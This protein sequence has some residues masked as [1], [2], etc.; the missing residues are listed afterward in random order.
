MKAQ[1]R[2]GLTL[3]QLLVVLALLLLLLA[4][5]LPA[6]AQARLAAVRMQSVNNLKQIALAAHNYAATFNN[7]FP[8][9][10]DANNFSAAARL[11][12]YVEQDNVFRRIDFKKSIDDKANAAMRKVQI[13]TF[14]NPLDAIRS[15]SMDYGATNYLFN[16]GSQPD[17]TDNN[18]IFYRDSKVGI[19]KIPDGTSN[20]LL[21]VETLKGDSGVRAVDVRRQHVLLKKGALGGLTEESGVPEWKDDK[22]IAADRGASWMDGRFLQGT[23]TGTRALNDPRPDVSCAG[24]GGLSGLRSFQDQAHIAMCDGSVRAINKNVKLEVWKNLASANDGQVIPN[25]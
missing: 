22:H 19:G 25:F 9:G 23:F 4:L 8:P 20:T 21:V 11:L 3:F 1:P 18:G 2:R 17:L 13:P 5:L 10:I 6:L 12:P 14:L 16:A 15:V 7:V 24:A